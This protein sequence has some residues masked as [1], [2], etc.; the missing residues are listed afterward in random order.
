MLINGVPVSAGAVLD[1]ID[2]ATGQPFAQAPCATS[3]HLD[4]AVAA[5]RLALP[6]WSAKAVSER[7]QILEAMAERLVTHC[8][9]LASILTREQGKPLAQARDE[10][11]SAVRWMTGTAALRLVD[12]VNE[13]NAE[14][15]SITRRLPIGVVGAIAPWNYPLLLAIFKLAPALLAGNTLV[16]KPSPFTPLTTLTFAQLVADLVPPGVLNVLSGDDALGPWMTSHPGFDKISFTGSTDTGRRIM[17][18]A[19][20]TLKRLTLE[21]GGNDAA[22]VLPDADIASAATALFRGSFGNCGQVCLAAKRIYVHESV[23]DAFRAAFVAQVLQARVGPGS[24]PETTIGPVNNHQQFVRLSTLLDQCRADGLQFAYIG[25]VPPGGGYFIPPTIIV[26]PPEDHDIVQ[27]EQFGPI[28]P[29][30][31]FRC[32]DDVIA[33]VNDSPFGLGGSVWSR[34]PENGVQVAMQIRSG[35]VCIN[36]PRYL[37]PDAPFG[38][39]KQSGLGV[40]GGLLGLHEYTLTQTLV[41]QKRPRSDGVKVS[42]PIPS[43]CF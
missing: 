37:A 33:K 10:I 38:G 40:E 22:I 5:A 25:D 13:D 41:I 15:Y 32:I 7:A 9:W 2:P 28:V 31:S 1:V 19:A 30:M 39:M 14:R 21:L 43:V 3:G 12:A 42:L 16:L 34:D 27:C 23:F 36:Q 20:P 4:D 26:A 8:D 6:A 18:A 24:D 17:A 11:A 29:L 35:T